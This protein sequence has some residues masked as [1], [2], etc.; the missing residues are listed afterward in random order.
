[1]KIDTRLEPM[2]ILYATSEIAPWSK[3][4]GLG[5][6]AASLPP[7]LRRLGLD[8]RLLTP[9]YPALRRAF[10]HATVVTRTSHLGGHYPEAILR[11][12]T[13]ADGTP[14][15]LID[16]A[17]YFDRP[18]TPYVDPHHRDWPDNHLRF[19]LLSRI[20]AWLGSTDCAPNLR[21]DIVHCNDWQTGLAPVYLHADRHAHARTVM[22]VHN[23]AFHGGFSHDVLHALALPESRW[24]FD[25]VEFHGK[26][27]FLKAGLQYADGITTVSPTYAR[28]MLTDEEGLGL[29]P[30]LRYRKEHLTGILNGI[31]LRE[32][33]PASDPSIVMK[34]DRDHL[35]RKAANKRALRQEFGLA[36]EDV[37]LLGVVS[38]FATQK[39][40]DLLPP[41]AHELLALPAQLVVLGSGE[42]S[43]ER[44]FLALAEAHPGWVAIHIGFDET[45]AHHIQAGADIFL[46]PSRFEP[47][48][49]A[50]MHA[51]RYGTLPVVRA[52]GGLADTVHDCDDPAV[53]PDTA[54]GFAFGAATSTALL[55]AL[56]RAAA[57]WHDPPRWRRLQ[58]NAM[59]GDYGW[60]RPARAYHDV[61]ACVH[62]H[63]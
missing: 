13:T 59:M 63:V 43:L 45:L 22:T 10:P 50:Q 49:L 62:E 47:C 42:P 11:A 26:L 32:W 56:R 9:Y 48:G 60:E 54:N 1:M 3:T 55:M 38:R 39:G 14:L 46:M 23:L 16:C 52:T 41:I 2:R 17:A 33:N 31:D 40:L 53:S 18:G 44:E 6:V 37:P 34:Y 24:R 36:M 20:A 12:A 8:V 35:D 4:G 28:E 25:G 15:L 51:L 29:A 61:Y 58:R 19:G 21:C 57:T 27:S 30:L 7:A 5:D